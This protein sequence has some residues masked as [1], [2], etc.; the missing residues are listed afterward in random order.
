MAGP[1]TAGAGPPTGGRK[2]PGGG[3]P[4]VG[5]GTDGSGRVR[6]GGGNG[7]DGVLN[8]DRLDEGVVVIA[9]V[10]IGVTGLTKKGILCP[11]LEVEHGRRVGIVVDA[12]ALEE[13]DHDFVDEVDVATSLEGVVTL[14]G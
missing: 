10:G 5:K 12:A 13:I 8:V 7:G 1:L 6:A 2:T 11:V 14:G 3:L 4:V 9:S